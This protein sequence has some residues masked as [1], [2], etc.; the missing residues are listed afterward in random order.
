M[1]PAILACGVVMVLAAGSAHRTCCDGPPTCA[2]LVGRWTSSVQLLTST[3]V[4]AVNPDA[5]DPH[6]ERGAEITSEE[7]GD[8]RLAEQSVEHDR[9]SVIAAGCALPSPSS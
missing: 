4:H 2:S 6:S 5:T 8:I 1:R 7:A 9:A 3:R